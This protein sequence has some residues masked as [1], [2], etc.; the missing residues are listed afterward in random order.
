MN[1]NALKKLQR[2][3]KPFD[4]TVLIPKRSDQNDVRFET[5]KF[6]LSCDL[7]SAA[8]VNLGRLYLTHRR[9]LAPPADQ[10]EPESPFVLQ[11]SQPWN[12]MPCMRIPVYDQQRPNRILFFI[13]RRIVSA[14]G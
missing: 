4:V 12:R 6:L 13:G 2:F 5:D 1:S 11:Q 7:Q 14:Y 10:L 8:I 9:T 3:P